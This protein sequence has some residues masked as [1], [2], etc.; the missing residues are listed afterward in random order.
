[1]L[2][3]SGISVTPH[4]RLHAP[5]MKHMPPP[6]ANVHR[7]W[8]AELLPSVVEKRADNDNDDNNNDGDNDGDN[9]SDSDNDDNDNDDN[10]D[11]DDN[12]ND[13]SSTESLTESSES[14]DHGEEHEAKAKDSKNA[15]GP[16]KASC[17]GSCN[18]N[19]AHVTEEAPTK[20]EGGTAPSGRGSAVPNDSPR[21]GSA[22]PTA[23][24]LA[25]TP[26]H[27]LAIASANNTP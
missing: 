23:T 21:G 20:G 15:A 6:S 7:V 17:S 3:E 25:P 1:M 19:N 27:Q 22:V 12:N 8:R 14:E 18:A 2:M 24:S 11:D 13:D 5:D 4:K 26:M 16:S 9:D 10:D